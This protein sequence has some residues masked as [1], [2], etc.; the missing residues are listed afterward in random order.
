LIPPQGYDITV[1][2]ATPSQ[3][4]TYR[5]GLTG[6]SQ[7]LWLMTADEEQDVSSRGSDDYEQLDPNIPISAVVVPSED[8]M[9]NRVRELEET[10][11]ALELEQKALE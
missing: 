1:C 3:T 6:Q 7:T 11:H 10:K 9:F 5:P 4:V 8:E 2:M